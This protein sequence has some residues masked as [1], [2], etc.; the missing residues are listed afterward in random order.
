MSFFCLS[1]LPHALF[2]IES[3]TRA[4]LMAS[5]S[6]MRLVATWMETGAPSKSSGMSGTVGVRY[7]VNR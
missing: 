4:I 2:R 3:T 1:R 5:S 6:R 7:C